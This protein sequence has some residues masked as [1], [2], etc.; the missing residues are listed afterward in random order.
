MVTFGVVA[1]FVFELSGGFG[2]V[3]AFVFELSGGLY[4]ITLEQRQRTSF[5][6]VILIVM[7]ISE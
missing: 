1:A 2:V 6:L 7:S 3:A 4:W 5:K